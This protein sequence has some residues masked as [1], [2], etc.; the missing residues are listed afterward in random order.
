MASSTKLPIAN[1]PAFTVGFITRHSSSWTLLI[2]TESHPSYSVQAP[3]MTRKVSTCAYW[4]LC[5]CRQALPK[6]TETAGRSQRKHDGTSRKRA[7]P[8]CVLDKKKRQVYFRKPRGIASSDR[9]AVAKHT[10]S[11]GH[12][13]RILPCPLFM[14]AVQPCSV[15]THTHTR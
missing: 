15:E 7:A 8:C 3:D 9:W 11:R 14:L 2:R 5:R 12:G 1:R 4:L 6:G 10:T 13:R